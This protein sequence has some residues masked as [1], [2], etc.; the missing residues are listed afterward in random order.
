MKHAQVAFLLAAVLAITAG[1][2]AAQDVPVMPPVVAIRI[3]SG[4]P[5]S[6]DRSYVLAHVAVTNG[7]AYSRM[8]AGRDV[9]TLLKTGRFSDV[10]ALV[11]EVPGGVALTYRVVPKPK[12]GQPVSLTGTKAIRASKVLDELNLQPGDWVDE[13][14]LGQRAKQVEELYRRE[15]YANAMVTGS[16]TLTDTNAGL[17]AVSFSVQEEEPA[18]LR[19]V[20]FTG[21]EAVSDGK[22]RSLLN[23]PAWWNPWYYFRKPNFD[24]A[25][26]NF[27]REDVRNYYRDLGYLDAKIAPLVTAPTSYGRLRLT[28]AVEEGPLYRVGGVQIRGVKLFPLEEVSKACVLKRDDTAAMTAIR[29]SAKAIRDFYGSRGYI[30]TVVDPVLTP[31]GPGV[32]DVRFEVREGRLTMVGDVIIRGNEV[33]REKVIRRE[34]NVYPGEI[35]NEVKAAQTERRLM[36]L[37][38]FENVVSY[39]VA[40]A[41]AGTNDLV[42]EVLEKPTGLFTVGAGFSSVDSLMGYI[43]ISQGNFDL[44]GWP[45]FIGGGQR[46]KLSLRAGTDMSDY[47]LSLTEPWF[48]NRPLSLSVEGYLTSRSYSEYDVKRTGGSTALAFPV[49]FSSRLEIRYRLERVVMSDVA[50]TNLYTDVDGSTFYYTEEGGRTE[51]SISALLS[52]DRRDSVFVPTRGS[53]VSFSATLMGGP[54]G[55]DTDLYALAL[56]GEQHVPLWFKHVLS[57]RASADVEETYGDTDEVPISERF[58]CGGPRTVRGIKYRDAGPKA[59][60]TLTNPDGSPYYDIVPRGGQTLLLASAEYTIPLGVPNIRFAG[61]FDAGSLAVDPYDFSCKEL[62]WGTGVGIRLDIP[63]FPVRLDYALKTSVQTDREIDD[64]GTERWSFWIGYG[65]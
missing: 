11:E 46:L 35:F 32:M 45:R 36:G 28:V 33:T 3:V 58:F 60:Q 16:L 12:L 23:L 2:A 51:S 30:R 15:G 55:F 48:L 13:P 8:A 26:M 34:V 47:S 53:R 64:T 29:T 31:A 44:L 18:R 20:V 43:E 41:A 22:L 24:S 61:F 5:L 14:L 10:A 62:V 65:F 49:P 63:G 40:T 4:G 59:Y 54:M 42:I 50:D 19:S 17:C 37:N 38:Y 25:D 52:R 9:T 1:S 7:E 21:N 57:F 6:V 27:R 39:P 56:K